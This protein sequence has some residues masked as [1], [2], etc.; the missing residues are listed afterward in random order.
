MNLN[1]RRSI[2]TTVFLAAV[3][4]AGSAWA[5]AVCFGEPDDPM[6]KG[7][8][9]AIWTMLGVTYFVISGFL[10]MFIT[11]GVRARKRARQ[12]QGELTSC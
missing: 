2:W 11:I 8:G 1:R 12:N 6:T 4:G 10:A 5:C 7:L 3:L 9:W